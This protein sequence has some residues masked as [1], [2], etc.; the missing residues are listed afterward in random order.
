MAQEIERKFLTS[1]G[2]WEAAVSEVSRISQVYLAA[3]DSASVRVRIKDDAKAF[4]TVKGAEAGPSRPEFEYS[5]PVDEAKAM[6]ALRTG[7][8]VE[9]HRHIV[10]VEG[11]RWEVDVFGGALS[12]LVMAELE[13]RDAE[14]QFHR[15]DW[16]GEEVTHDR[17]YYNASLA[18]DGLPS[19]PA[20]PVQSPVSGT[21]SAPPRR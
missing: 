7:H 21:G 9:K 20:E 13:L 11:E 16:L 15:P 3:T 17:R 1:S 18:L 14:Q 2:G 8:I 19:S 12:G 10:I 4:L 6:F 5:I